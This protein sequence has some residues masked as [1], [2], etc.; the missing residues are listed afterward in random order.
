MLSLSF[1]PM[2]RDGPNC[3]I[4]ID[5]TPSCTQYLACARCG[6]DDKFQC[7]S[8]TS[9]PRPQ[10]HHEG[11]D[12]LKRHRLV[13]PTGKLRSP[14][15]R[16]RDMTPPTSRIFAS[17]ILSRFRSVEHCFNSAPDSTGSFWLISPNWL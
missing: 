10:G 14:G 7:Q 5:F 17:S 16:Q 6:Q 1:H 13:M 2:G 8:S 4:E 15:E 3:I 9:R 12:F 11:R